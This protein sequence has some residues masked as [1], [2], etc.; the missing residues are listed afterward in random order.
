[1]F[2]SNLVIKIG[3][4]FTNNILQAIHNDRLT[5]FVPWIRKKIGKTCDIKLLW[6]N[7]IELS[8][9]QGKQCIGKI[10]WVKHIKKKRNK[11]TNQLIIEFKSDFG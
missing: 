4:I 9:L 2:T 3:Y 6:E 10:L 11:N 5:D 1:M 7:N 8:F